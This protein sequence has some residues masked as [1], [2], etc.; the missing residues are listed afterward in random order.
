MEKKPSEKPSR[1]PKIPKVDTLWYL[2]GILAGL[3]GLCI[4]QLPREFLPGYIAG[5]GSA[6]LVGIVIYLKRRLKTEAKK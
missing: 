4:Y 1:I 6:S 3:F 5:V 2:L